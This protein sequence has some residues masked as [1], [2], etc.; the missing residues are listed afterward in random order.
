MNLDPSYFMPHLARM[1]I[2][3]QLACRINGNL[4]FIC[5]QSQSSKF[6][7]SYCTITHLLSVVTGFS[8]Q[9]LNLILN[10]NVRPS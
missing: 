4:N 8:L 2:R 9:N 7:K 6:P 5:D 10:S 3:L 1:V